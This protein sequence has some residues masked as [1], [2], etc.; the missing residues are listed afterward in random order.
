MDG[1]KRWV[2]GH[3]STYNMLLLFIN[4]VFN[5]SRKKVQDNF[6]INFPTYSTDSRALNI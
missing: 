5:A 3:Y 1:G 6:L 4:L 2:Y